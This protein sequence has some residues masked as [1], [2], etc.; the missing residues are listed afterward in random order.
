MEKQ[1]FGIGFIAGRKNVCNI[2]N[3]YYKTILEQLRRECKFNF[4]CTI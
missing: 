2:I 4:F 1:E 3:T